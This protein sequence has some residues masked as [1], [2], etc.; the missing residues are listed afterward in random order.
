[1]FGCLIEEDID[2]D[3][4]PNNKQLFINIPA[5]FGQMDKKS[6]RQKDK[7]TK[8]QTDKNTKIQADK[9]TSLQN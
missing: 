1:M 9:K 2:I 4:D 6:K 8:R 3:R 7:H 5:I